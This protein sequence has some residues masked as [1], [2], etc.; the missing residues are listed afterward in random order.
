[1]PTALVFPRVV[2]FKLVTTHVSVEVSCRI[3]QALA[4]PVVVPGELGEASG[5]VWARAGTANVEAIRL[6]SA[7]LSFISAPSCVW[8]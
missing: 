7:S 5:E 8:V 3:Y 6:A 2:G 4:D 1:M